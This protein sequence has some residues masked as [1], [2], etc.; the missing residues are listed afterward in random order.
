MPI[1][2]SPHTY[3]PWNFGVNYSVP[4]DELNQQEMSG[5]QD[6]RIGK[7]GE[8]MSRKGTTPYNGTAISGGAAYTACGQH[9][10]NAS[11]SREFAVNG[12]KFY[13]GASGTWTDR[14][15]T[16][17]ITAGD[18]NTFS[19]VDANG[20]RVL[21]NGVSGD[22]IM[23]WTAAGG[24]AAALDVDSRFTW[25]KWTEFFDNRLWMA[26]TSTGTDEI[27]HSDIADI[28]T[29]GAT[30]FFQIGEIITGVKAIGDILAVHSERAIRGSCRQA[31]P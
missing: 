18:D 10:F 30:S 9:D 15:S 13:E 1:P 31:M 12:D 22:N 26:N 4:P 11:T 17:T 7:G 28:E 14:S 24:N 6:V 5:G 16:M 19:H 27:W 23:K 25:A 8:G 21:T 29:W 20:T 2:G 3:G